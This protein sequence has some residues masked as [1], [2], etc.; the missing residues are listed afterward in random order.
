MCTRVCSIRDITLGAIVAVTLSVGVLG[1]DSGLTTPPNDSPGRQ[2]EA[3]I[4]TGTCTKQ[5]ETYETID[6]KPHWDCYKLISISA[7]DQGVRAEAGRSAELWQTRLSE[8]ANIGIPQFSPSV[9]TSGGDVE[10]EIESGASGT[11]WCGSTSPIAGHRKRITL[12]TF[13]CNGNTDSREHILVHELAHALGWTSGAHKPANGTGHSDQ[14]AAVLPSDTTRVNTSVCE[15]EIEGI[16][17]RYSLRAD[18]DET[19]FWD[20]DFITA[21]GTNKAEQT[22]GANGNV[23]LTAG[24]FFWPGGN[25]AWSTSNQLW[26]SNNDAVARVSHPGLVSA[27]ATGTTYIRVVAQENPSGR[28]LP[29]WLVNRGD[30]IK[31]TVS[32]PV[33][34]F[35]RVDSITIPRTLP[36]H[37][38]DSFN[39]GAFVAGDG[40]QGGVSLSWVIVYSSGILPNDSTAFGGITTYFLRVPTGSYRITAKAY[41]KQGSKIGSRTEVDLTVCPLPGGGQSI[42]IPVPGD[43]TD[44][45]QGC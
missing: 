6:F 10:I 38:A 45:A 39:L 41:P 42:R 23:Q 26:Y 11:K 30:S 20:R 21:T 13:N 25:E 7:S 40:G 31:V 1:C 44:A 2:F 28:Y 22:L 27:V 9:S 24:G 15:H 5:S 43:G 14:C 33:D 34:T 18:I 32:I 3:N 35:L 12:T 17:Y 8:Y 16:L 19:H 4:S 36:I 29:F 37:V